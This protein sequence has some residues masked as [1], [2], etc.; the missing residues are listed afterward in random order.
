MVLVGQARRVGGLV[1]GKATIGGLVGRLVGKAR[2]GDG[3]W[4]RGEWEGRVRVL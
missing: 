3:G 4:W 1:V 2:V